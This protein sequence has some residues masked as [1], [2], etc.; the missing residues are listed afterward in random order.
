MRRKIL[1]I[2]L[3]SLCMSFVA[4]SGSKEKENSENMSEEQEVLAEGR[5]CR[6]SMMPVASLMR[7]K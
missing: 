1:G 2:I 3:I 4:C 7:R 5:N 6:K